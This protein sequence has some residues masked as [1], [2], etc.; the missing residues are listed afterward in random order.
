MTRAVGKYNC[1]VPAA[2]P[3]GQ[4][5]TGA[6]QHTWAWLPGLKGAGPTQRPEGLHVAG[7]PTPSWGR[8]PAPRGHLRRVREMMVTW[9]GPHLW[10]SQ[11]PAQLQRAGLWVWGSQ[12][13]HLGRAQKGSTVAPSPGGP[14]PAPLSD[15]ARSITP[16]WSLGAQQQVLQAT[17]VQ[18][19]PI[20]T[21]LLRRQTQGWTPVEQQGA[22]L[23]GPRPLVPF[24]RGR[25]DLQ[26][27][28]L[29]LPLVAL[30]HLKSGFPL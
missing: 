10:G 8:A 4:M 11:G 26:T 12:M 5:Q 29:G 27:G 13:V 17:R 20:R 18:G 28:P 3:S 14:G 21:C 23:S 9:L 19:S 16:G 1:S 6:A 24:L 30:Q 15:M 22:Q 25:A 7:P 2:A